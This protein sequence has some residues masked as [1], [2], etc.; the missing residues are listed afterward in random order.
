MVGLPGFLE[1]SFCGAGRPAALIPGHVALK[2]RK[3]RSGFVV[4]S[5]PSLYMEMS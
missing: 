1:S 4:K 2:F 5:R 3:A